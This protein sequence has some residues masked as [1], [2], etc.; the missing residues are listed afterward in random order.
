MV[1]KDNLENLI[2][3]DEY[4]E[5]ESHVRANAIAFL[6]WLKSLSYNGGSDNAFTVDINGKHRDP[7]NYWPGCYQN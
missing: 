2:N 1:S 5:S 6:T 4:N 3:N 7:N